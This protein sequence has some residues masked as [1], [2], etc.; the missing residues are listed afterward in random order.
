MT[1]DLCDSEPPIDDSWEEIVE[2]SFVTTS[3]LKPGIAEWGGHGWHPL[4]LYTQ[5]DERDRRPLAPLGEEPAAHGVGKTSLSSP[6]P[7]EFL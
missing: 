4:K 3:P 2:V 7:G 6:A 5:A 1:V